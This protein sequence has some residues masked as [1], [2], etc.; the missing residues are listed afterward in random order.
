V[1]EMNSPAIAA[2]EHLVETVASAYKA[3]L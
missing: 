1:A 3:H 2:D